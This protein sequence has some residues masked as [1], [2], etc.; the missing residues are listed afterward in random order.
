MPEPFSS[1]FKVVMQQVKL[2]SLLRQ[3]C[4]VRRTQRSGI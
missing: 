3:D 1:V 4:A 2:L